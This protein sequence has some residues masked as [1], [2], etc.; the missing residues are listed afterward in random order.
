MVIILFIC[1][2]SVVFLFST[3]SPERNQVFPRQPE[4]NNQ[5]FYPGLA[6]NRQSLLT[7]A[8]GGDTFLGETIEET[9]V[10]CLSLLKRTNTVITIA[11]RT[12][13]AAIMYRRFSF[14]DHFFRY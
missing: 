2:S 9:P 4:L 11:V 13:D 5:A 3:S 12:N 6:V 14:C 7:G 10:S 1:T 8:A